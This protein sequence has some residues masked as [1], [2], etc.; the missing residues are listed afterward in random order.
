[1]INALVWLLQA[2][3]LSVAPEG[4]TLDRLGVNRTRDQLRRRTTE[5]KWKRSESD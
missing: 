1:V 2:H 3:Y 5:P 4:A